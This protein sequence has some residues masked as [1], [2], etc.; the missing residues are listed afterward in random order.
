MGDFGV[1]RAILRFADFHSAPVQRLGLGVVAFLFELF[2]PL[3]Q[4]A[5]LV[6]IIASLLD[7]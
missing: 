4:A 1:I 6:A 7:Q 5:D 3:T 2:R